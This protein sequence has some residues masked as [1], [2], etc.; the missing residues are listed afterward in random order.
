[1]QNVIWSED[2]WWILGGSRVARCRSWSIYVKLFEHR[3]KCDPTTCFSKDNTSNLWT[4]QSDMYLPPE[5]F[6]LETTY[7][8]PAITRLAG[9]KGCE[10][11]SYR[12]GRPGGEFGMS[13]KHV[14]S[15]PAGCMSQA[16]TEGMDRGLWGKANAFIFPLLYC[17]CQS[18]CF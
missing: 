7:W 9:E 4:H 16:G 12:N 13:N 2:S 11:G 1:M 14:L 3:L 8:E 10:L 18:H 6:K 15:F 5:N 17:S